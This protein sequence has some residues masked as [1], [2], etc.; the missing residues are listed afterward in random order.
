MALIDG[1]TSEICSFFSPQ[2]RLIISSSRVGKVLK[3]KGGVWREA[4][5]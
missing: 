1:V 5:T 3:A 4:V 2:F